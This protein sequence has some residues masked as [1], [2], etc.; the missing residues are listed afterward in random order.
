[1][2]EA[3]K[4]DDLHPF[5]ARVLILFALVGLVLLAWHLR[6]L[7]LLVFGAVLV[8]VILRLIAR[9]IH[10]RL[11]VGSGIALAGA[12]LLVA[13]SFALLFALFGKEV[14]AQTRSLS[15]TIPAAW[16]SLQ[17]RL[18]ALGAG[19][20][21]R[22]WTADLKSGNGTMSGLGRFAMSL[23]SGIADTLLVLVGGIYLAAQPRLYRTGLIKVMPPASR[24]RVAQ[25]LEECAVT[26]TLWLKGRLISMMVVAIL[27]GLGLWMIGVPSWLSL[28]LLSGLLEFIPYLGPILAAVPAILLALAFSSE[29][30]LW[31]ALLY[32]IVQQIEGY[33]VEPM[34]QQHV[35]TIPPALL[36]FA[37]V[38]AGLSFGFVGIV[39]GAPLTVVIYVLVKY[40]YVR[41]TLDTD[42][43]LPSEGK[44]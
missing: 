2:Y 9:P 25:A 44:E 34:V 35:V 12:V 31:T 10:E 16:Q 15:D 6:N 24:S 39:L 41:E 30:G 1:M 22:Q 7:L 28:A 42:T 37:V 19:A 18:D 13:G 3:E 17:A 20:P 40:L 21:L 33:L 36:L 5:I 14:A 8:S 26:L 29:A 23:G 4:P 38:A 27:T 32:L 11:G 43:P